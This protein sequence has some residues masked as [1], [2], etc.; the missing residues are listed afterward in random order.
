MGQALANTVV[1]IILHYVSVSNQRIVHLKL[2]QWYMP[3]TPQQSWATMGM[4]VDDQLLELFQG[5]SVL[6]YVRCLVR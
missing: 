6:M 2:M 1:V 3:V 5:L 4:G